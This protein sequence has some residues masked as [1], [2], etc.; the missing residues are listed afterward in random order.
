MKSD[1]EKRKMALQDLYNS[2]YNIIE[3]HAEISYE[4]KS[5]LIQY[6][7]DMYVISYEN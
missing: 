6:L 4:Q 1:S 3:H 7:K 5:S 2:Y